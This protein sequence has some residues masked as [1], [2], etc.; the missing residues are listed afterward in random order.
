MNFEIIDKFIKIGDILFEGSGGYF[1]TFDSKGS[2]TVSCGEGFPLEAM[3]L[4]MKT[5]AFIS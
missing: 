4:V 1:S 3:R 5:S 2:L